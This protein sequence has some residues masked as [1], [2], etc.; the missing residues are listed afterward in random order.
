MPRAIWVVVA[1]VVL[2]IFGGIVALDHR[3]T[4]R[5]AASLLGFPWRERSE[6]SRGAGASI[7]PAPARPPAGT[8]PQRSGPPGPGR[9]AVL[10]DDLGARAD[11]FDEILALGRPLTVGVLP[12]LPL[13]RRLAREAA[14]AGL[15]VVV[16][17]PLEPY[18]F[19]ELDPGPGTL[20]ISMTPE[21]LGRRTRRLLGAIP[22]AAGV[23]TGMG[24]RFTEDRL[25]MRAVLDAVARDGRYFVDGLTSAWSVGF[26]EAR[27]LGVPAARRQVLL[28]PDEDESTV[29]A[30]LD[31]VER[32][33]THRGS[34]VAIAHGR[35]LTVRLLAEAV[36]RWEAHGL[37]LVPV[38]TLVTPRSP[39]RGPVVAPAT[40]GWRR[41]LA[42]AGAAAPARPPE[43]AGGRVVAARALSTLGPGG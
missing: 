20:L 33:A 25:R 14:R 24:S 12:D 5:G 42:P 32:W 6:P 40:V 1:V 2:A 38:S 39:R 9:I 3:Q 21:D 31:W 34:V 16:Q 11:V 30:R 28:D 27:S 10:V 7:S 15:E 17:L 18:R 36:P 37:R 4:T 23:S 22:E 13:S 19:P 41:P 26:D 29:R 43:R 8:R 35:R